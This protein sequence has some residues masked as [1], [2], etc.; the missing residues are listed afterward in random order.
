MAINIAKEFGAG[1][2]IGVESDHVIETR[3]TFGLISS[4]ETV[5]W[6]LAR[7]EDNLLLFLVVACIIPQPCILLQVDFRPSEDSVSQLPN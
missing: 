4:I 3:R 7:M 2:V 1:K 6:S 5:D